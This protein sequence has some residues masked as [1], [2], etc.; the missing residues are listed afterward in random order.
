MSNAGIT[1]KSL[2]TFDP[3]S[4]QSDRIAEFLRESVDLNSPQLNAS[5]SK[6]WQ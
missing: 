4:R 5:V 2:E 1:E 3:H 6:F